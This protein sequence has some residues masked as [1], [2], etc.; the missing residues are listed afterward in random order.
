[1]IN[2]F[3][4]NAKEEM[5][6]LEG[7]S[8]EEKAAF[9]SGSGIKPPEKD[10]EETVP[11]SRFDELKKKYEDRS[12]DYEK[13]LSELR[14]KNGELAAERDAE[15]TKTDELRK[16]NRELEDKVG[17]LQETVRGRDEDIRNLKKAAAER[18]A[19]RETP[20]ERNLQQGLRNAENRY[21][22]LE[23]SA[24]YMDYLIG[25]MALIIEDLSVPEEPEEAPA[26]PEPAGKM[27]RT[28][29]SDLESDLFTVP[30]YKAVLAKSGEYITFEPDMNGLVSCTDH[31]MTIPAL[32]KHLGYRGREEYTVFRDGRK[33]IVH[34]T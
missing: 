21:S 20:A 3:R 34:L 2:R 25:E 23:Q 28:G 29:P 14:K 17:E 26:G 31:K 15:K 24:D 1:M 32:E 18:N 30:R 4:H 16:K 10:G 6:D 33:L 19:D 13:K 9:V 8:E 5:P 11:K 12:A 22:E 7:L 27:V